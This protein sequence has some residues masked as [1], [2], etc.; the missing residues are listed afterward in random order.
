MHTKIE[1]H[2][3]INGI[4]STAVLLGDKGLKYVKFFYL[5]FFSI[6]GYLSWKTNP[7]I[8]SLIIVIIFIFVMNI[9]LN[10]WE[11]KSIKSSNYYFKLN[12][13]IG[14]CCFLFLLIF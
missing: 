2:D 13:F 12:N 9:I 6:I 10:K 1:M 11:I 8:Y 7:N 3:I 5:V 14:L 4:K